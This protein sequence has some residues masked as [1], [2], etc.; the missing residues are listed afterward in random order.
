MFFDSASQAVRGAETDP[1]IQARLLDQGEWVIGQV[2]DLVVVDWPRLRH[3][4]DEFHDVF[5]PWLSPLDMAKSR[6]L[7]LW[8]DDVGL[9][10][11]ATNDNIPTFGTPALLAVLIE[12]GEFNLSQAQAL[13]RGLREAYA[14]DLPLDSD[15]LRLSAGSDDWRAGPSAFYF[16]RAAAWVDFKTTYELWSE[17]AQA[18][19]EAEPVRV[20]GWLHAAALG[21]VSAL[22]A[23]RSVQVLAGMAAKA[24]V[25]AEFDPQAIAACA[26]RVRETAAPAGVRNPVPLLMTILLEHLTSA[27]GADNAARLLLSEH[28]DE[29]DRAVLVDLAFGLGQGDS[30][31]DG[32]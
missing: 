28:L 32:R 14:V 12:E 11:L 16:A 10:T 5:L 7:P 19:A 2:P 24:A 20:A 1:E 25:L 31:L 3:L 21:L 23:E 4:R 26:A 17:L 9:R 18:A 6:G 27:I 22:D 15:W 8:C 30:R 29:P 13:L